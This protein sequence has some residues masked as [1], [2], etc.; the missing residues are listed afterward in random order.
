MEESGKADAARI[1]TVGFSG[2]G[3]LGAGY[4]TGPN[5]RND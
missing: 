3:M 2:H 5:G 4:M 1:D